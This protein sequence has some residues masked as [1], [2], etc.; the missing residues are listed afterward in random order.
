MGRKYL[1]VTYIHVPRRTCGYSY[2]V[3]TAVP[4]GRRHHA[5]SYYQAISAENCP[6]CKQRQQVEDCLCGTC[7]AIRKVSA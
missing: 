3:R 1:T 4:S 2:V 6:R 5:L 7:A